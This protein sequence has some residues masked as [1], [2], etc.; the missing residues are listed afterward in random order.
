MTNGPYPTPP[1]GNGNGGPPPL[2]PP[3]P[4]G[5]GEGLPAGY[6]EAFAGRHTYEVFNTENKE[7]AASIEANIENSTYFDRTLPA[8]STR[9]F[10]H[11][12]VTNT[13]N[14]A[15]EIHFDNM[16]YKYFVVP[17]S[18]IR[19]L[20]PPEYPLTWNRISVKN[21]SAAAVVPANTVIINM[22]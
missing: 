14:V 7:I 16:P 1:N 20:P 13:S 18:T 15:I 8:S 5:N 4:D 12:E 2:V 21:R 22:W 19:E 11:I 3:A 17:A 10:H 9:K 6:S